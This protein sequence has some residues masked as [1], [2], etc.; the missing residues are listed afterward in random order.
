[1]PSRTLLAS[2]LAVLALGD[3]ACDFPKIAERLAEVG[4]ET[5]LP[6]DP[7]YGALRQQYASIM[8]FENQDWMQPD[9]I[10]Y[11]E[12]ENQVKKAVT[13]AYKC[14]IGIAIRSGGHHFHGGSS[15]FN[16]GRPCIQLDVSKYDFLEVT[17]NNVVSAGPGISLAQ[18]YETM[19]EHEIF[20]PAGVCPTVHLGGHSQ[21]G[22]FGNT[23]RTQ[24]P[25]VDFIK[26]FSVIL[27]DGSKVVATADEHTDLFRALKG[28]SP[29]AFGVVTNVKINTWRDA[30]YTH[31]HGFRVIYPAIQAL[32]SLG[33][34]KLLRRWNNLFIDP[35]LSAK[36]EATTEIQFNAMFIPGWSFSGTE[37]VNG[38]GFEG[39]YVSNEPFAGSVAEELY[40]Y[41]HDSYLDDLGIGAPASNAPVV[42]FRIDAPP[43]QALARMQLRAPNPQAPTAFRYS[44]SWTVDIPYTVEGIDRFAEHMYQ[45]DLI[46]GFELSGVFGVNTGAMMTADPNLESTALMHRGNVYTVLVNAIALNLELAV[47]KFGQVL[48]IYDALLTDEHFET[49]RYR[50]PL[51]HQAHRDLTDDAVWPLY[52]DADQYADMVAVKAKYDPEWVFNSTC[53]VPPVYNGAQGESDSNDSDE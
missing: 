2:A 16:D 40:N 1:M 22:G 43:S 51:H 9:L 13:E 38:M 37:Q 12:S 50:V 48:D 34:K 45:L 24:G 25:L 19:I 47:P 52:Y 17:E 49:A 3:R 7:L 5:Y 44:R 10:V 35:V 33:M 20:F 32:G 21:T 42:E 46:E 28:G 26:E 14:D 23:V 41:L 53:G 8:V 6:N 39:A 18:L 15:C 27:G 11:V 30:D 31:T 36:Y 4:A 29:G